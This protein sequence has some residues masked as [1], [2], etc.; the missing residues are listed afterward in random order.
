MEYDTESFARRL[1]RF[2]KIVPPTIA[3]GRVYVATNEA[4]D[5]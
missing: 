2:L 5:R 4:P 3:N 1:R